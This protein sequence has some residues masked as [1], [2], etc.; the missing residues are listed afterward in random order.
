MFDTAGLTPLGAGREMNPGFNMAI[1]ASAPGQRFPA[2]NATAA[3][4]AVTLHGN[5]AGDGTLSEVEIL[6]SSDPNLDQAAVNQANSLAHGRAQN[7]PG[8]TAQSSELILTF[9]FITSAQ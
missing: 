4:Q 2:S 7:Q 1:P 8:A 5:L 3:M 6:A 9:E